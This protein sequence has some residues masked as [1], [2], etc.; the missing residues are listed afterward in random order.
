LLRLLPDTTLQPG[1]SASRH[2]QSK[3]PH[4]Y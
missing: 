1:L 4:K 2:E 3:R